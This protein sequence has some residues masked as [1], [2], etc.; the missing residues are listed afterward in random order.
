MGEPRL[1]ECVYTVTDADGEISTRFMTFHIESDRGDEEVFDIMSEYN[2]R[3]WYNMTMT[4]KIKKPLNFET[5]AFHI[6][7]VVARVILDFQ[8][9]YT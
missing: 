6:F 1:T 9:L 7:Q 2:E 3:N 5:S 4:V 8:N